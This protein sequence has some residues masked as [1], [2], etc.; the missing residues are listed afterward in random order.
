MERKAKLSLHEMRKVQ[1]RSKI[2]ACVAHWYLQLH[3]QEKRKVPLLSDTSRFKLNTP[4]IKSF[5]QL[6]KKENHI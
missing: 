1:L 4:C 5:N 3:N 2:A 6:N